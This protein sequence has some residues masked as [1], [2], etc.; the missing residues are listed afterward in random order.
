[1]PN[2]AIYVYLTRICDNMCLIHVSLSVYICLSIHVYN[3]CIYPLMVNM[4]QHNLIYKHNLIVS[5]SPDNDISNMPIVGYRVP[6]HYISPLYMLCNSLIVNSN[7]NF[8]IC[9]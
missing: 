7:Y 5:L 8:A 9:I 1:M 2:I 3:M 4:Y 6:F